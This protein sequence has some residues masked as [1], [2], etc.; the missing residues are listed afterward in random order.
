MA[1]PITIRLGITWVYLIPGRTGYLLVDAGP[2]GKATNFR[3]ALARH[4][5]A[6]RQIRLIL[7][8]HVHYDHVGSLKAIRN[9][10]ACPVIVHR[11]EAAHLVR[12]HMALP[13]GTR[14]LPRM[15]IALARRHPRL[16]KRLTC[17]EAV[18]P[19]RIIDGPLDLS[20]DGFAAR[21]LP[22]PG[23]TMG[24]ISVVTASGLAFVGDLAV[25]YLP[26]GRGPFYPPFG[27]SLDTIR[28]SWRVLGAMG[29]TRIYPAH[30]QPFAI[31]KL[32]V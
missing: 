17:F 23:H 7:V 26:G 5:I 28:Q 18:V 16:A 4:G 13:P 27:D 29:V 19:D 24:S 8:T 15:L 30:G 9:D 10:C 20:P 12:G 2:R 1:N 3:R 11:A 21:V 32:P 14:P 6:P 31:H 22:T 25:N